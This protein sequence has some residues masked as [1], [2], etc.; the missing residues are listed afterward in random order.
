MKSERNSETRREYNTEKVQH[1]K[2]CNMR[3]VQNEKRASWKQRT[4]KRVQHGKKRNME[5]VQR[6]ES[7]REESTIVHKRITGRPLMDRYT[8]C[9]KK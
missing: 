7:I 5:I 8:H 6:E 3:R 9:A 4:T 2:N 1:E